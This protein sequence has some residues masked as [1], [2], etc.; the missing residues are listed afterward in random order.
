MLFNIHLA[1]SNNRSSSLAFV[2]QIVNWYVSFFLLFPF[3]AVI[4]IGEEFSSITLYGCFNNLGIC[5]CAAAGD[6][7]GL[8]GGI[9]FCGDVRLQPPILVIL[10][11]GQMPICVVF[12]VRWGLFTVVI[13]VNPLVILLQ[14]LLLLLFVI[15][16][17]ATLAIVC[18]TR[19]GETITLDCREALSLFVLIPLK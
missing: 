17:L 18:F 12:T 1:L 6:D 8:T 15:F 16:C 11:D 4:T 14:L 9:G 5:R 3:V 19:D 2:L 10:L 7:I 13:S